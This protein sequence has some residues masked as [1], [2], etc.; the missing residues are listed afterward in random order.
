MSTV[1]SF[2]TYESKAHEAAQLY[3]SLIRNSRITGTMP[4]PNGTKR[5]KH[6][7]ALFESLDGIDWNPAET[8]YAFGLNFTWEDG[9][10]Q[11]LH[12]FERPQLLLENGKPAALYCAC[13]SADDVEK[14]KSFNV[15]IKLKN[16]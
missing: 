12:K 7:I 10:V 15:A 8:A 2:I 1:T 5:G 14:E 6:T 4:G 3:V 13:V 16:E 9:T 11:N